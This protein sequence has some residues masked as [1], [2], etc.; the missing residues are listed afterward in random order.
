MSDDY[1]PDQMVLTISSLEQQQ[2]HSDLSVVR[3]HSESLCQNFTDDSVLS[4]DAP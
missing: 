2:D 3:T 1:M 4:M